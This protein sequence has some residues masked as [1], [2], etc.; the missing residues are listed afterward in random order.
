MRNLNIVNTL[1]AQKDIQKI[2][3][4]KKKNFLKLITNATNLF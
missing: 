3:R 2:K 4:F 1:N